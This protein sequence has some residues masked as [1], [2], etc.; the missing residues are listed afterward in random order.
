MKILNKIEEISISA[1]ILVS[2]LLVLFNVFLR[3]TGNGSIWAEELIR[4]LLIW[5][6]FIGLSYCVRKN[7]HMF[8][9]FLPGLLKG[10]AKKSLVLINYSIGLLFA[11]VFSWFSF[12]FINFSMNT[13]QFS[14]A[15]NVPMYII[16]IVIPFSGLLMAIRY[17]QKIIEV[18]FR[19][20]E[21]IR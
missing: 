12:E 14:P 2:A 4:Y 10:N 8:I 3:L 7:D 15:L 17:S 18:L 13:S 5:V 19:K 11:L 9:D 1:A 16:Y 6:T 21:D 20:V